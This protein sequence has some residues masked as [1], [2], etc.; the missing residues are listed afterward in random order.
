MFIQHTFSLRTTNDFSFVS[1]IENDQSKL[2]EYS[3][4]FLSFQFAAHFESK[5][6]YS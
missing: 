6:I 1:L 3:I 4:Q 5:G 2:N